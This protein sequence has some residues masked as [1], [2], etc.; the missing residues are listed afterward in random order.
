MASK[1]IEKQLSDADIAI[2][3]GI[4]DLFIR[5]VLESFEYKMERMSEGKRLVEAARTFYQRH[6]EGK[7][8]QAKAWEELENLWGEGLVEY[9]RFRAI[10]KQA[11][12]GKSDLLKSLAL[13]S[14]TK[15]TLSGFLDQARVFY[16]NAL[17]NKAILDALAR[18]GVKPKDLKA[19]A[20][21]IKKTEDAEAHHKRQKAATHLAIKKRD[22]AVFEVKEWMTPYWNI[23]RLGLAGHPEQL[24]KLKYKK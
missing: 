16:A 5:S 18:F 22:Q 9:R 23:C 14:Q 21:G 8:R 6:L 4:E 17:E 24:G 2:S 19:A 11:L 12:R 13:G 15:K 20:K 10:A 3:N 7:Y 1:I